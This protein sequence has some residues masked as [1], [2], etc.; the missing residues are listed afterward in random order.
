MTGAPHTNRPT[1]DQKLAGRFERTEGCWLWKGQIN[2][3]GYGKLVAKIEGK[4]RILSAHRAV[5]EHLVSQIP[6]GMQLDHLCRNRACVNPSH[7]EP[8]SNREN[9]M[10]GHSHVAANPAKTHCPQGHEYAGHNLILY[11]S[12]RYCRACMAVRSEAARKK[13]RAHK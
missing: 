8:V 13:R 5:Y 11:R 6:A 7:L 10:R 1:M 2:R 4:R 3:G 12:Y 9:V